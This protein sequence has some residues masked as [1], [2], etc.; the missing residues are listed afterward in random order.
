MIGEAAA[1]AT[2]CLLD[3]K[4]HILH[5][6]WE[7]DWAAQPQRLPFNNRCGLSLSHTLSLY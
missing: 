7:K 1:V 5:V 2:S 6:G 4:L 3:P